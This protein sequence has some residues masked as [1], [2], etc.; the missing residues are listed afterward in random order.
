MSFIVES[1]NLTK[2]YGGRT[3]VAGLELRI[4][5]GSVYGAPGPTGSGQS[6]AMQM[7]LARIRPTGGEVEVLGR[8]MSRSARRQLLSSIGSLIESPPGY[9]HL[10]GAE[11]M[12][13]VQRLLGLDDAQVDFA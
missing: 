12:R 5:E 1:S 2:A 10:T 8:P 6:T 13:I 7:L 3:V 4:P 9:A 11:N